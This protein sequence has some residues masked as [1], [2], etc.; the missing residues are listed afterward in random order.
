MENKEKVGP[1]GMHRLKFRLWRYF[2]KIVFSVETL[3]TMQMI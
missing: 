2:R 3:Q 1:L